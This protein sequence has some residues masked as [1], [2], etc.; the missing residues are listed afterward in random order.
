[1]HKYL[2][3]GIGTFF[4]VTTIAFSA[5]P[6]A[7]GIILMAMVYMGG[8]IS[9]GH[10]N[11]AVTLAVWLQKKIS[12]R[13]AGCYVTAQFLGAILASIIFTLIKY[14]PLVIAPGRTYNFW[15]SLTVEILFTFALVST[16]LHVA[17]SKRNTPNQFYGLAIGGVVMA[18]AFS[19]GTIS[20]GA[21]N[22]AVGIGPILADIT[23]ISGHGMNFLLYF[24]GPC[25]GAI[26]ASFTYTF[27]LTETKTK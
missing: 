26:L 14:E 17:L 1:M 9:G 24:L 20:G 11:P 6:L 27:V 10:Y 19:V 23:H 7:I 18:G 3:E 4:L 21:F 2:I 22:P 25:I 13:E 12:N 16:V 5:N 15:H 8:Y